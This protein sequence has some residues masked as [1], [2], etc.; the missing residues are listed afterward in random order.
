MFMRGGNLSCKNCNYSRPLSRFT[1][2][3]FERKLTD[4]IR[5]DGFERGMGTTLNEFSCKNKKCN[6]SF[7]AYKK[8]SLETCPFC[9]GEEIE[10]AKDNPEYK[11]RQE[12]VLQPYSIIPF[13][14]P[15]KTARKTLRRHLRK[16]YYLMHPGNLKKITQPG[17]LQP[18]YIPFFLFDILVRTSW[19][20]EAGV[21]INQKG[22]K[23]EVWDAFS[24]YFEKFHGNFPIPVSKGSQPH[25]LEIANYDFRDLVRYDYHY[26]SLFATE[27]YQVEEAEGFAVAD[28]LLDLDSAVEVEKKLRNVNKRRNFKITSEKQTLTFKHILVPVWIGTYTYRGRLFQYMINGQTGRIAGDKP[29]SFTKIYI[30]IAAIVLLLIALILIFR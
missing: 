4:G 12:K 22:Q 16:R 27:I 6:A 14:I 18:I 8:E 7:A 25:L 28:G 11:E 3:V 26:L 19:K 15:E 5:L 23:K 17:K 1:D 21:T 13:T 30:V 24:G 20:G 9:G 29:L 2:Q 10:S